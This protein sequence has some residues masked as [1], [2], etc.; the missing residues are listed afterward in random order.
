MYFPDKP[1]LPPS[2]SAKRKRE[3]FFSGTKQIFRWFVN[4]TL[5][6]YSILL[7][8]WPSNHKFLKRKRLPHAFAWS[9]PAL[10]SSPFSMEAFY[11]YLLLSF[12][13]YLFAGINNSGRSHWCMELQLVCF[14]SSQFI[15]GR[16]WRRSKLDNDTLF[17][18]F[19]CL[20]WLGSFISC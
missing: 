12:L 16:N 20:Q 1:P 10:S 7:T 2:K 11:R 14:L 17:L 15:T 19:R 13:D 3:D 6:L 4:T 8:L 18:P 9:P 5:S